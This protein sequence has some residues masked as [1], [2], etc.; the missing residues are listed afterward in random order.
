M[1]EFIVALLE[2]EG[3][4]NAAS[5]EPRARFVDAGQVSPDGRVP[6]QATTA[7]HSSR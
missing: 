4:A 6:D 5:R 3:G 2:S 1:A 7:T